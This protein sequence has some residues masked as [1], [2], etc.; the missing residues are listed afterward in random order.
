M[1]LTVS[2]GL[3]FE[4]GQKLKEYARITANRTTAISA[5]A[6][7]ILVGRVFLTNLMCIFNEFTPLI[8][9]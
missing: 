1:L 2:T 7:M 4:N 8:I 9:A 6:K 3:L 5:E